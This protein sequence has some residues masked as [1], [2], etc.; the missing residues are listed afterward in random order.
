MFTAALLSIAEGQEQH[1]YH[2]WTTRC[3]PYNGIL[4]ELEKEGKALTTTQY[5]QTLRTSSGV[6]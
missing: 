2:W 4:L 1:K 3:S 5:A 6:K